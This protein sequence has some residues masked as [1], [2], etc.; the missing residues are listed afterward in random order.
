MSKIYHL[1]ILL[2]LDA[3]VC[4]IPIC[5]PTIQSHADLIILELKMIVDIHKL[6]PNPGSP[7]PSTGTQEHENVKPYLIFVI[8]FT[9]AKFLENKIYTKKTRKL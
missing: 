2:T 4:F 3:K 7:E 6:K 9:R 8:F 1:P 5:L